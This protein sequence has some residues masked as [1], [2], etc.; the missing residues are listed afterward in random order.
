MIDESGI[1]TKVSAIDDQLLRD[2]EEVEVLC[3]FLKFPKIYYDKN[4]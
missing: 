2:A 3:A 1:I 4:R